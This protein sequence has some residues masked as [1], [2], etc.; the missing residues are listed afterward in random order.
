MPYILIISR[1]LNILRDIGFAYF[2]IRSIPAKRELSIYKRTF[3]LCLLLFIFIMSSVDLIDIFTYTVISF[4]FRGICIFLYIRSTNKIS[5]MTSLYDAILID[6]VC[7]VNHN[8]FL[9]PLTRPILNAQAIFVA[10]PFIN[11]LL[12]ILITNTVSIL[13]YFLIFKFIQLKNIKNAN[14]L[15]IGLLLLL[16]LVS[17]YLNSTLKLIN[18]IDPGQAVQLSIFAIIL[19]LSLLLCIAF[20]ERYKVVLYRMQRTMLEN[21]AAMSLL[22]SIEAHKKND[23]LLREVRHDLKNHTLSLEHLIKSGKYEEAL[24]YLNNLRQ[25]YMISKSYIQTG[26]DI[27]DGILAQKLGTAEKEGI[28]VSVTADFSYIKNIAGADLCIIFGNLLDNAV[29]ACKILKDEL[30]YINIRA[31]VLGDMVIYTIENSC[32]PELSFHGGL[33]STTKK[34]ARRHGIGLHSVK[35]IVLKNNGEIALSGDSGKFSAV[36][37]FPISER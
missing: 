9:T 7:V 19:Q 34:E 25:E 18:D 13:V 5:V 26:N 30:R 4:L 28:S 1:I 37:S 6:T 21:E 20:F 22:E 14:S 10:D 3:S 31:N 11:R 32:D 24:K 17:I 12:C 36:L 2:Y 23:E 29:E 35:R 33:P 16:S 8:I 15:Q 27:L